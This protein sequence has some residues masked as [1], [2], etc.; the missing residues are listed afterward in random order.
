MAQV[1]SSA[2]RPVRVRLS[3]H[4]RL[5]ATWPWS[6]A[7]AMTRHCGLPPISQARY[8]LGHE[9][10][11]VRL[12]ANEDDVRRERGVG[13]RS[14]GHRS[15]ALVH[16]RDSRDLFGRDPAGLQKGGHV[17]VVGYLLE[18]GEAMHQGADAAVGVVAGNGGE[19]SVDR[20]GPKDAARRDRACSPIGRRW[21]LR[22]FIRI[23]VLGHAGGKGDGDGGCRQSQRSRE[24]LCE[25]RPR[26]RTI[27][28]VL[29]ARLSTLGQGIDERSRNGFSRFPREG[30]QASRS[31]RRRAAR[32]GRL[33]SGGWRR[34][35]PS[36]CLCGQTLGHDAELPGGALIPTRTMPR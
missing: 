12:D 11:L 10:E 29:P 24:C 4:P 32:S 15:R 31:S 16:G 21:R 2:G 17:R 28:P 27:A 6:L 36:D 14:V 19:G 1:I 18:L 8:C 33:R 30:S 20:L 13:E 34:P 35:R 26:R 22:G 3:V 7:R 23:D 9:H 25:I 5:A